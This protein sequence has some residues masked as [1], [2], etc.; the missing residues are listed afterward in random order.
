LLTG[1]MDFIL[2]RFDG[3][4]DVLELKDPQDSI[5]TVKPQKRGSR[6]A[7]RPS[8]Y[9]LS[10]DLAQALGQ[11]HAYRD[12]L[13]RHAEATE[14]LLGLPLSRDP[15]LII[16]IGRA[17]RLPEHSQRVLTELNKSLHRVAVVPYDVLARR[18]GAVLDNVEKYLLVAQ[19]QSAQSGDAAQA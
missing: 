15:R 13:T 5:I 3:F 18:A 16:V 10:A 11:V 2:E 9:A 12:R 8:A 6:A 4:Q 1:T 14:D 17:D 7:P 19:G